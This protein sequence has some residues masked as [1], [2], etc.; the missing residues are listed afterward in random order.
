MGIHKNKELQ[1]YISQTKFSMEEVKLKILI[2]AEANTVNDNG[3]T[4]LHIAI[5]NNSCFLIPEMLLLG[6][7]AKLVDRQGASPLLCLLKQKS[8]NNDAVAML[9]FSAS[10]RR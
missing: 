3:D 5:K 8:V 1:S 9:V 10:G 7:D 4:L 6:V 2:G